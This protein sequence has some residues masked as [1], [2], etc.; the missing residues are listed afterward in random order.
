MKREGWYLIA[1]DIANPRRLS[2][3]HYLLK[4][5]GLAVQ[6]SL[7]FI[8]GTEPRINKILDRIA[9][10]M[11]LKEDDLRA[12]PV[13]HPRKI[14]TFGSNPLTEFPV[15]YYG[16]GKKEIIRKNK[17]KKKQSIWKRLLGL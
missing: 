14:W 17:K 9:S 10:I 8:Q 3:I 11:V 15:L 7:F 6:K 4:K 1:Y 16:P 12:Y 13:S 5:E 2:K